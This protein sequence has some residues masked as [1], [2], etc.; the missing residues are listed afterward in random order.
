MFATLMILVIYTI[1]KAEAREEVNAI[2]AFLRDKLRLPINRDKSRI[3]KPVNSELPGHGSVPVY[4]QGSKGQYQLVVSMKAWKDLKRKLKDISGKTR[5]MSFDDRLQQLA[6][7]RKG[8][9]D[10]FRL[11]NIHAN[12]KT[13]EEWLRDP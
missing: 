12:L 8:W 3:R 7:V 1:S 5:P 10:N 4:S 11:E 13:L 6:E 2:C 9:V